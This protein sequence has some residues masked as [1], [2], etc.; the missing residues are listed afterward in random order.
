MNLQRNYSKLKAVKVFLEGPKSRHLAGILEFKDGLYEFAYKNSYLKFKKAIPVGPELPLKVAIYESVNLFPSFKDRIPPREN[1][2]YKEYC[3]Q[4]SIYHEESNLLLLLVTIGRKGPSS[5]VFEPL[6]EAP[7]TSDELRDFRDTLQ[8]STRDFADA[9]GISQAQIVRI[10]NNQTSG[11]ETLKFLEIMYEF[12]E[13]G[14]WYIKKYAHHLHPKDKSKLLGI[15]HNLRINEK[16][17][18]VRI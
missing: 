2:A 7:F 8:L 17:K 18:F 4:F 13:I 11:S 15:Y 12:P 9:F 10:E 5:F 16:K 6:W 1:P 14:C 3:E